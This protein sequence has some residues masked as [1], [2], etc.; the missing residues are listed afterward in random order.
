MKE[1]DQKVNT[2]LNIIKKATASHLSQLAYSYFFSHWPVKAI[3]PWQ[4]L[5]QFV[6]CACNRDVQFSHSN[7]HEPTAS[8]PAAVDVDLFCLL[9]SHDIAVRSNIHAVSLLA[10]P[11]SS[12]LDVNI[13]RD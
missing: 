12:R 6:I 4:R 7:M 11:A 5:C 1:S 8:K 13:R 2:T 3:N 9:S 10:S